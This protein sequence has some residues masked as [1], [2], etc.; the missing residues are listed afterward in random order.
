VPKHDAVRNPPALAVGRFKGRVLDP[1]RLSLLDVGCGKG[2]FLKVSVSSFR[3]LAGCDPSEKMPRKLDSASISVRLRQSSTEI[4]YEHNP[5]N[6]VTQI[7]VRRTPVDANAKL[8]T[9][10]VSRRLVNRAGFTV[11]RTQHFPYLP[12]MLFARMGWFEKSLATIP[13]GGQYALFCRKVDGKPTF[14]Y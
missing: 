7:I 10:S 9:P 14:V 12:E 5:F 6:P 3:Q 11:M 8:L 13:F 1:S 4:P 2:D